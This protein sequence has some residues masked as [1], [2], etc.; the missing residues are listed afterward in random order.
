MNMNPLLNQPARDYWRLWI[1]VNSGDFLHVL[2]DYLGS[3]ATIRRSDTGLY[4]I[5]INGNIVDK[6]YKTIYGAKNF[7][8][9][10]CE[11]RIITENENKSNC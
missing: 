3:N 7:I 5:S 4:K 6:T 10:D 9:R 11:K 2:F 8:K 1:D